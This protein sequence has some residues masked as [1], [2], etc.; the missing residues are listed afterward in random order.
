MQSDK[1]PFLGTIFVVLRSFTVAVVL[2]AIGFGL[3]S[4]NFERPPLSEQ[5]MKSVRVGMTQAEVV[6]ILGRPNE[7]NDWQWAYTRPLAWGIFKVN[8][9]DA[10]KVN[11]CDCDK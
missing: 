2:C 9:D 5:K 4:W 6:R 1:P 11:G 3:L 8:F 10:G 7:T